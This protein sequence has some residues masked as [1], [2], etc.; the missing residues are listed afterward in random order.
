MFF[1]FAFPLLDLTDPESLN[2]ER[3]G[4]KTVFQRNSHAQMKFLKVWGF[5]G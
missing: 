4:E 1:C 5:F 2:R 3:E